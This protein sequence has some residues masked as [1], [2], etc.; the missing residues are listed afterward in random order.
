MGE[1]A[2]MVHKV[3][4]KFAADK[5]R[6]LFAKLDPAAVGGPALNPAFMSHEETIFMVLARFMRIEV[7]TLMKR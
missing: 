4:P 3:C 6:G 1:L 5:K 7:N 2:G